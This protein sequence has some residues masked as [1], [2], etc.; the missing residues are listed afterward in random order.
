MITTFDKW[1]SKNTKMFPK[2]DIDAYMVARDFSK[3]FRAKYGTRGHDDVGGKWIQKLIA[4]KDFTPEAV[5]NQ[6]TGFGENAVAKADRLKDVLGGTSKEWALVQSAVLDKAVKTSDPDKLAATLLDLAD[7]GY[8][9]TVFDKSARARMKLVAKELESIESK[10]MPANILASKRSQMASSRL[11]DMTAYLFRRGGIHHTLAGRTIKGGMYHA[12]S[13]AVRHH[14]T[15]S[16]AMF[17]RKATQ[18]AAGVLKKKKT[19]PFAGTA[20]VTGA[21]AKEDMRK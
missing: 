20:G 12:A 1:V 8:G 5:V 10:K 15:V 16:G 7:S 3:T 11:Q 17:E 13:R 6:M 14:P 21:R 9:K 18:H 19:V 4:K 2:K